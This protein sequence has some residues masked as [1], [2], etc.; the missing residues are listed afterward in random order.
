MRQW[1]DAAGNKLAKWIDGSNTTTEYIANLVY[2]NDKISF[3]STEEGRAIPV[4]ESGSINWHF[5]YNLKDHLGNTRV[6]FGGSNLGGAVDLVQAS[7]Y[8]PFGMVMAQNNFNTGGTNYQLNKYIYNGKELQDD[9]LGGVSLDCYDYGA[10]FYDPSL[11]RWHCVDPLAEVNRKWSPYRYAYNNPLRFIDP[12]G[13]LEDWWVNGD[14]GE[15]TH[16]NGDAKP[17][18]D[19]EKMKYLGE[20]GMF[21]SEGAEVEESDGKNNT[22]TTLSLG[23]SVDLA[24]ENG[25]EL[26]PE[27]VLTEIS[28]QTK[29]MVTPSGTVKVRDVSKTEFWGDLTYVKNDKLEKSETEHLAQVGIRDGSRDYFYEERSYYSPT[30]F[31][32]SLNT[33]MN[34]VIPG[35]FK[36]PSVKIGKNKIPKSSKLYNFKDKL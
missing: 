6:T 18:T 32:K 33:V 27:K 7:S 5:E 23:K 8:Y 28:V 19:S 14:T 4:G 3:F 1:R 31:Q 24:E 2:T 13:M 10:R 17:N 30:K 34:M 16:T 15:L 36:K 11:G 12:D 25:Y 26:K 9:D 35:G 20:D 22:E 29:G 21:G